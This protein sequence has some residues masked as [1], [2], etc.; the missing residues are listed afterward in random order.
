MLN[1]LVSEQGR[2]DRL[3]QVDG[4]TFLVITPA[5][6]IGRLMIG[7][8]VGDPVQLPGRRPANAARIVAVG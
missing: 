5:S 7:R 1:L 6:P 2:A 8:R 3:M 4:Q